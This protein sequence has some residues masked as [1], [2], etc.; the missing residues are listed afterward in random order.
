MIGAAATAGG[1]ASPS[2]RGA[3]AAATAAR[4][5]P[6]LDGLPGSVHNLGTSFVAIPVAPPGKVAGPLTPAEVQAIQAVVSL[7][8]GPKLA[9]AVQGIMHHVWMQHSKPAA[10]PPADT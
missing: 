5:L 8:E 1:S 6:V 9:W 2:A 3:A 7:T 4:G 10:G